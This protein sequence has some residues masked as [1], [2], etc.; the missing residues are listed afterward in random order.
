MVEFKLLLLLLLLLFLWEFSTPVLTD[1]LS[2]KFEWQQVSVFLAD[3]INAVVWVV[4][5]FP[6]ISKFSGPFTNPLGIVPIAPISLGITVTFTFD[7]FLFFLVLYQGRGTFF[8]FYSEVCQ[9]V[10][11]HYSEGSLFCRLSFD[12]D[13]WSRLGDLFVSR[14]VHFILHDEFWFVLIPL[15]R[16]IKFQILAQFPVDYLPHSV[17][18]YSFLR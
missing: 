6:L 4:S 16:M 10:K 13:V 2:Q 18:L 8:W 5:Y 12:L 9:D 3:L 14:N 7:S 1:G 15:D 11:V 17:V